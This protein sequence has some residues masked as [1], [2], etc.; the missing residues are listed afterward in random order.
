MQCFNISSDV[1]EP[2]FK[3]LQQQDQKGHKLQLL[4]MFG[5]YFLCEYKKYKK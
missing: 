1:M 3:R 5:N 2:F 4:A